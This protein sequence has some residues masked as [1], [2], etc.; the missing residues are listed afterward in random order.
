LDV[1]VASTPATVT[2]IAVR[3]VT[4]PVKVTV[5]FGVTVFGA[6]DEIVRAGGAMSVPTTVS[7][8]C[9]FGELLTKSG[10]REFV[11]RTF[12]TLRDDCHILS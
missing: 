10:A 6:G 7:V 12:T 8:I 2:L 5:P 3:S 9:E 11:A 4:P 1:T